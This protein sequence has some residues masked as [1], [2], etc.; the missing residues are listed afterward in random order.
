MFLVTTNSETPFASGRWTDLPVA[1]TN[2]RIEIGAEIRRPLDPTMQSLDE[3]GKLEGAFNNR[4]RPGAMIGFEEMADFQWD[5]ILA[6]DVDG[7]TTKPPTS[8][9]IRYPLKKK[10]QFLTAFSNADETN[11]V[12]GEPISKENFLALYHQLFGKSAAL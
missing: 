12:N 5:Q 2:G 4:Q 6:N 10:S 3:W 8:T 9:T 11:V 1:S 7:T